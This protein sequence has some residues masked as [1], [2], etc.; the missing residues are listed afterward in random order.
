MCCSCGATIVVA[1]GGLGESVDKDGGK[2]FGVHEHESLRRSG[3]ADVEGPEP[4]WL[5]SEDPCWFDD[6]RAI[7]FEPFDKSDWN[8]G[9]L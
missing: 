2:R 7:E 3:E 6:D 9:D 4:L 1:G 8:Q 5:F